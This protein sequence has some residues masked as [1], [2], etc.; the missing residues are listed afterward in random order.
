MFELGW[1]AA[2]H[3]ERREWCLQ[4]GPQCVAGYDAYWDWY[5]PD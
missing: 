4:Y 2:G 5:G 3:G 1:Q